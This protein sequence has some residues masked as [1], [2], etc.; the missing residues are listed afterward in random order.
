ALYK[1]CLEE[2]ANHAPCRH[3]L[4]VLLYRTGRRAEADHMI[5]DWLVREPKRAEAY[6]EDGWRLRQEG[7]LTHAQARLQ[8][9][10]DLDATNVRALTEMALLF[11]VLGLPERAAVLYQG[12]LT[13]DPRQPAVAERLNLLRAKKVG[14]PLPD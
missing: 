5:E 10:L 7:E 9:A 2:D 6:V 14:K 4:A 1:R 11:E 3:A 13:A 12:V 8:Q